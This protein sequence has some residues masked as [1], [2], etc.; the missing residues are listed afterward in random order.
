MKLEFLLI[1]NDM[2][3]SNLGQSKHKQK[4]QTRHPIPTATPP[5]QEPNPT[6]F[7]TFTCHRTNTPLY[8]QPTLPLKP[9][10]NC[11]S[12]NH[13]FY[14]SSSRLQLPE[15]TKTQCC[16][17]LTDTREFACRTTISLY[18]QSIHPAPFRNSN[19]KHQQA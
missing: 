1:Q 13:T 18:R 19:T 14:C 17:V 9:R 12:H 7:H 5:Q 11:S 10:S 3:K 16:T 6:P 4:P 15:L 2:K 8:N